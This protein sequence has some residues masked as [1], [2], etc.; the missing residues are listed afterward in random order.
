MANSNDLVQENR[1]VYEWIRDGGHSDFV[2]LATECDAFVR[3]EQWDE[4]TKA[5]L[6]KVRKP[7]LT[8]NKVLATYATLAGEHLTRRGDISFRAAS[9]GKPETARAL[10]KLWIHF[11]QTNNLKW[12]EATQFWDG[13]VRGRGFLDLR[14]DFDETMR[15]EPK[16]TYINS[17]DVGLYPTDNG[18][19]PDDWAG[20]LLSRWL[21]AST[22]AEMYNVSMK[23]VLFFADREETD[24]DYTDWKRDAFGAPRHD[25]HNILSPDQRAKY[26]M[27]RVMERQ[28]WEYR[29]ANCFVDVPTGEVREI[30]SAWDNERIQM[31]LSQHGYGLVRRRVRKIRWVVT[32]GDMLLHD[33]ISPYLHFTPIPYFPFLVGGRPL[34]I[35]QQLRDPQ[36]LLN[37]TLSQNLHIIAGIANSGWKVKHGALKNMTVAQL[38]RRG[39]EDGLVIEVNTN[40]NDIEKIQP[41]QVPQGLDRLSYTAGELMQQISLVNDSMQGLNRA[42]ESGVA[43]QSKS[44]MGST[45]LS[46][47]YESLDQAR[48]LVARNWLDLVQQFVTEE[49]VYSITNRPQTS[50]PEE[51]TVNKPQYDGSFLNDLT[52]GEYSINVTNVTSRDSYD[53]HQFEIMMQMVREGAP[54]PWSE[55]VNSLSILENRTEVVDYLKTQEGTSDPS[56]A[57]RVR[58]ELEQRMMVAEA[59]D[60]EASA[61]VKQAQAQ[62]TGIEAQKSQQGDPAEAHKDQQLLMLK[63]QEA[64]LKSQQAN[65]KAEIDRAMNEAKLEAE[66]QK[67]A[68]QLEQ[69]REKHAL[70]V[71]RL[72]LSLTQMQMQMELQRAQQ[73]QQIEAQAEQAKQKLDA[74]AEQTEQQLDI[75]SEQFDR[76][77]EMEE[78]R[79]EQQL[80]H[81]A[82]KQDLQAKETNKNANKN[83]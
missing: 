73:Q 53:Q 17:K 62:R 55:I 79:M 50:T 26:R 56:E 32:V 83:T 10:D 60:K 2:N 8:I 34:G 20:T 57:E 27:L 45:A 23:D 40:V 31:A 49:R 41:N 43:I 69:M 75:E 71:K 29:W 28:E 65:E 16:I 70:E 24:A 14:M 4:K 72:E 30:P 19:D 25:D 39:G 9:G 82:A 47:I 63:Q 36:N 76:E 44:Q 18:L 37:K 74:Q 67:Q 42:D 80:A 58:Q 61:S 48:G 11:T 51:I 78:R 59:A 15:G 21:S 66:R 54:I 6:A 35:V 1:D 7:A 33:A 5:A 3:G 52:V 81:E 64:M 77:M 13:V 46:P 22:I 12:R 68:L 38:E